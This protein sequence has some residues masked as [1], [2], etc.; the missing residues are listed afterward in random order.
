MNSFCATLLILCS[1]FIGGFDFEYKNQD[2]F[3]RGVTEC[4]Q[5]YNSYLPPY[6]RAY[7]VVSV[8]QA[9]LESDWGKS[10]FAQ[11]GN[12]FYGLIQPDITEPHIT[13]LGNK[14]IHVK[15]YGRKCESVADYI[16]LLNGVSQ[17]LEYRKIRMEEVVSGKSNLIKVINY[18][19]GFAIDPAYTKKVKRTV[20]YLMREYPEIFPVSLGV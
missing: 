11:L 18:L 10:R 5:L 4:T 6:Q 2:E 7:I 19:S 14:N 15:K 17:F 13:A 8:A 20:Q 1:M 16:N 3:V 9:G 12:N